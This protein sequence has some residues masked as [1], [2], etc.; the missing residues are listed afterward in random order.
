MKINNQQYNTIWFNF[1]KKIVEIID[2]N[3]LP[4]SFQIKSLSTFDDSLNSI[5]NMNVRGAPLIGASAAFAL[6]LSYKNNND[7]NNLKEDAK[8]LISARPTAINLS[9]AVHRVMNKIPKKNIKL[10][11]DFF[12][13]EALLICKEDIDACRKIGTYG[14]KLIK[15]IISKKKIKKVNILT[16]CNAGWLATID[17]GTALSP[18]YLAHRSGINVHVWVDETRPRNQGAS[19]TSFELSEEKI[20]NTIITDN[21]GGYL[22]QKGMV[23]LCITGADRVTKSGH[24]IN[25]IGTYLKALAAKD[26]KI[27]FYVAAPISTIDWEVSDY[28]KIKIENRDS[29]ELSLLNGLDDKGNKVSINIYPKNSKSINPSFDITPNHLV[30]KL[31]TEK[32][33]VNPIEKE[34]NKLK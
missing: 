20:E 1:E 16:H 8:K 12:L 7:I 22:M 13:N 32:G 33:I 6:Y 15:E 10:D 29:K 2:Q 5:R 4:F 31:I 27:P 23:D 3:Q 30:D 26:S 24:V 19:L 21:A 9:W 25:K 11:E 28:S 34:I 14:L 17:W 18:I